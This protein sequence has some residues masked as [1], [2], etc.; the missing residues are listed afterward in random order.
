[1]KAEHEFSEMARQARREYARAW[2]AKNPDRVRAINR[3]YWEKRATKATEPER[4]E[5]NVTGEKNL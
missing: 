2:R 5:I 3:R 1:M 4:R